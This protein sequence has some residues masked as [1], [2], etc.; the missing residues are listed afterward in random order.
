MLCILFFIA[1]FVIVCHVDK[2]SSK[3][4]EE[5]P[6]RTLSITSGVSLRH[7]EILHQILKMSALL[8]KMYSHCSY[9]VN[10]AI[11]PVFY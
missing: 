9:R 11:N 10:K 6:F 1:R 8:L 5:L 2:Y 7:F 3:V 4:V